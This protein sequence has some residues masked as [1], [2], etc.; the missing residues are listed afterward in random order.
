MFY[1]FLTKNLRSG[2]TIYLVNI[3][4]FFLLCTFFRF[5]LVSSGIYFYTPLLC[6]L[7][8]VPTK[9]KNIKLT[10]LG[11]SRGNTNYSINPFYMPNIAHIHKF[12]KTPIFSIS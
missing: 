1:G 11:H 12:P 7:D 10:F 5:C 3:T 4:D 6:L 8:P 2:I 9:N